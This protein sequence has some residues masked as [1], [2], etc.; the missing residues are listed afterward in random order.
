[1]PDDFMNDIALIPWDIIE[2]TDN[3]TRA[4][5]MWKQSILAV[6]NLDAP[7]KK[8]RVKNSKAPWLTREIKRLI[9]ERD[10]IKR[11]ATVTSVKIALL[12]RQN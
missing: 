7:V 5:E 11:I 1:M 9:W 4:W 8:R 10:R 12:Q 6:A 3:P 2:Q